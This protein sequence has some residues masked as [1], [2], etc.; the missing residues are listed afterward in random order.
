M[1]IVNFLKQRYNA[2]RTNNLFFWRDNV[3]NEID[4]LIQKG[5]RRFPVE[6]KSG[7]TI[8]NDY[9]KGILFWNKITQTE[10][11][12]VIYGGDMMQ[13]RSNGIK[14]IPFREFNDE[15]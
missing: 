13:K 3:G 12:Y 10:G 9:F 8:T 7:Q 11:G 2:G 1:I 4:L 15:V 14:V 5:S 6:I